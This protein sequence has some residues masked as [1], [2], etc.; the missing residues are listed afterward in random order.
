MDGIEHRLLLDAKA[1]R[2]VP[3]AGIFAR[4]GGQPTIDRMV[5]GLYDRFESDSVLR[6]LFGLDLSS[7]RVN[8]KRFFAEWMGAGDQY[9]QAAYG[10]LK[11]RHDRLP[12]T[13][14]LAGRWLGHLRR[15]L[16]TSVRAEEDRAIIFSHAQAMAFALVN[17]D[18]SVGRR[19]KKERSG[20]YQTDRAG[21]LAHKGDLPGLRALSKQSPQTFDHPIKAAIIMQAA[22]MARR[23]EVVKWLLAAGI[24]ANKPHYLPINLAGRAFERVLFVTPYVCRPPQAA[25][26]GGG[27]PRKEWRE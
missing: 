1:P 8:Q 26:R 21:E 10:T 2:R 20:V 15:A 18:D 16:D 6:P 3:D 25:R 22:V 5:D 11:H 17:E 24:D 14:D 23:A 4:I 27:S 19:T 12:I 13:R 9:S 7:E